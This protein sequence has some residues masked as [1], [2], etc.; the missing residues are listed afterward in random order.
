[1]RV[2]ATPERVRRRGEAGGRDHRGARERDRRA[3]ARRRRRRRNHE[4]GRRRRARAGA[5]SLQGS[6]LVALPSASRLAIRSLPI[7]RLAVSAPACGAIEANAAPSRRPAGA[8]RRSR[9]DCARSPGSPPRRRPRASG[10]RRRDGSATPAS[11]NIPASRMKPGSTTDTPT[12]C[13]RRS[14]RSAEREAPQAELGR[15]VHRGRRLGRLARQRRDEHHVAASAVDHRR[16]RSPRERD[17]RPQVDLEHPVDLLLVSSVSRPL[18]GTP[19][20]ATSTSTSPASRREPVDLLSVRR[21]RTRSRA[22][23]ARP[24][25]TRARRLGGR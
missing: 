22:R 24:R 6:A 25:A 17:R 8:P 5:R 16:Q 4:A 11:A 3:R 18:A 9:P 12:P 14:A 20:L 2:Q 1:M 10:C 13:G 23:R 19:A 15:R 21:G 7:H